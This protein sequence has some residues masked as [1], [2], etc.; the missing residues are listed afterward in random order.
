MMDCKVLKSWMMCTWKSDDFDKVWG[1]PSHSWLIHRRVQ[2]TNSTLLQF[3]IAIEHGHRNHEFSHSTMLS[4]HCKL[5]VYQMVI[6]EIGNLTINGNFT[7]GSLTINERHYR[8]HMKII[9]QM[10]P[11]QYIVILWKSQLALPS[12]ILWNLSHG[13]IIPRPKSFQA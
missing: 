6:C 8:K 13:T 1:F 9:C 2:K 11:S 10:N 3:K 4:F 7:N 12:G 5:L